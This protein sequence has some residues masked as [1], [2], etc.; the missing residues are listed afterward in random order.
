MHI[1]PHSQHCIEECLPGIFLGMNGTA[2]DDMRAAL[3]R[4]GPEP[5]VCWPPG[6]KGAADAALLGNCDDDPALSWSS[7]TALRAVY[8]ARSL[9]PNIG[10]KLQLQICILMLPP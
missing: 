5:P 1:Q 7:V 8:F 6:M 10:G 3:P 4:T 9:I 2:D